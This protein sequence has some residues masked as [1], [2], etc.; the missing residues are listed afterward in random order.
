MRSGCARAITGAAVA[1]GASAV[2]TRMAVAVPRVE[3][4]GYFALFSFI[5]SN[6]YLREERV[7]WRAPQ[8]TWHVDGSGGVQAPRGEDVARL[9]RHEAL[10][11]VPCSCTFKVAVCLCNHLNMSPLYTSSLKSPGVPAWL[12]DPTTLRVLQHSSRSSR[13][14]MSWK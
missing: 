7:D 11:L 5:L 1:H 6:G 8:Y 2:P 9:K 13:S 14:C 10:R 3:L 12:V 4:R